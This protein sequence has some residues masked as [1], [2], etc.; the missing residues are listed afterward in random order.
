MADAWQLAFLKSSVEEW[1]K[2]LK[3]HDNVKIDLSEANL[4]MANLATAFLLNA[5]L[6]NANLVGA[7][8]TEVIGY[9]PTSTNTTPQSQPNQPS[10]TIN[11]LS[12]V[13]TYGNTL[14]VT[15]STL[16]SIIQGLDVVERRWREHHDK[17][18]QQN[19]SAA[20][21]AS[22]KTPTSDTDIIAILL[23]MDDG[24]HHE[25]RRW[26]SS[27]DDLRS[28]IDAFRDPAS[29]VKPLSVVFKKRQGRSLSV[30]ITKDNKQLNVILG[31][32]DAPPHS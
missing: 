27:P 9:P 1:N 6:T 20:H 28:Y 8:L 12:L 30:N 18:L 17:H 21:L 23:V 5:N 19:T 31:Y 13:Q 4:S 2:W 32:I 14:L 15:A 26:V 16:A 3:K 25:F 7:R 11:W 22:S 10:S 29:P 24:S